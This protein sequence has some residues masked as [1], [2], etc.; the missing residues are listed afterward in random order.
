MNFSHTEGAH[1]YWNLTLCRR[2]KRSTGL[3]SKAAVI[4]RAAASRGLLWWAQ[5]QLL[6]TPLVEHS[7]WIGGR[8]V[9][10]HG[11]VVGLAG[12]VL[13]AVVDVVGDAAVVRVVQDHQAGQQHGVLQAMHRQR[14]QIVALALVV[15][16]QGEEGH[17]QH[18]NDRAANDGVGDTRVVK[19]LIFRGHVV[20]ATPCLC[21]TKRKAWDWFQYKTAFGLRC[22]FC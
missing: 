13:D 18:E 2:Q 16:H 5:N 3:L 20:L 1:I 10:V 4:P 17:H 7:L 8:G 9:Q 22:V 19:Q 6:Y 14:H 21:K 11:P 12:H 15:Q